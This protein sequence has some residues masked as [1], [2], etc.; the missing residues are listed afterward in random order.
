M[1]HPV[2]SP[3]DLDTTG[4]QVVTSAFKAL[5]SWN[6]V[7]GGSSGA[8]SQRPGIDRLMSNDDGGGAGEPSN[9]TGLKLAQTNVFA[10]RLGHTHK[11][12]KPGKNQLRN[13][14]AI[15]RE[16]YRSKSSRPHRV[17]SPPLSC[18]K[19]SSCRG[20]R[21]WQCAARPQACPCFSDRGNASRVEGVVANARLDARRRPRGVESCG[22]RPAA[23]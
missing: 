20:F 6:G 10:P 23:T 11:S 12:L 18:H 21:D 14:G 1:A 15:N 9:W 13:Y 3:A 4:W 17:K 2:Y 19:A 7:G 8:T 16:F 5:G 22:R